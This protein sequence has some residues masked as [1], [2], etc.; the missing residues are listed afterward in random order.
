MRRVLLVISM[1]ALLAPIAASQYFDAQALAAANPRSKSHLQKAFAARTAEDFTKMFAEYKL[2]LEIQPEALDIH[3]ALLMDVQNAVGMAQVQVSIAKEKLLQGASS[4]ADSEGKARSDIA[5]LEDQLKQRRAVLNQIRPLYEAWMEQHPNKAIYPFLI[6]KS[7]EW[8]EVEKQEPL[9]RRA[10]SLDPNYVPALEYM[11]DIK[12]WLD[13]KEAAVEY[14]KKVVEL[15]VGDD[16]VRILYAA[17]LRE[18]NPQAANKLLEEIIERNTANSIGVQAT[19]SL[20]SAI[21]K[22]AD[23]VAAVERALRQF[24][25]EKFKEMRTVIFLSI[26][27]YVVTDPAK[28][29]ELAQ[30]LQLQAGKQADRYF[31]PRIDYLNSVVKSNTLAAAGKYAEAY[32]A[33]EG[34]QTPEG[35]KSKPLALMKANAAQSAGKLSSAYE[36]LLKSFAESADPEVGD[37][38]ANCAKALGQSQEDVAKAIWDLRNASAYTLRDL[39]LKRMETDQQL[40]ISDFKGK[41]VLLSFW[42]PG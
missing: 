19:I 31:Q 40:R 21:D 39:P 35:M 32:S 5:V 12:G 26:E 14:M 13:E 2:A 16:Q 17:K 1:C 30:G 10:L 27:D 22:P 9:L 18:V 34:I 24:P 11:S 3:R 38:L 28:G 37:A 42:H 36:I 15:K 7:M 33:L 8:A 29:L 23:K 6:A 41:V 4:T 25:V 20:I